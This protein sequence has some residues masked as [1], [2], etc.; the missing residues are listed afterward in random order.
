MGKIIG[1]DLGTN[2]S[3]VAVLDGDKV[4][5]LENSGDCVDGVLV[6]NSTDLRGTDVR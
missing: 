3:C 5:V 2:N 4:R 1:I 6:I